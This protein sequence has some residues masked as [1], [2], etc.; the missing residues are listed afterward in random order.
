MSG[1]ALEKSGK[2]TLAHYIPNLES[3]LG[4]V[5]RLA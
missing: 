4:R 1:A 5:G 3:E 2:F